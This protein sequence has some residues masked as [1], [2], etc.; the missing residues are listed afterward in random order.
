MIGACLGKMQ[1]PSEHVDN[2]QLAYACE[3]QNS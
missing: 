2:Q 1:E 3:E